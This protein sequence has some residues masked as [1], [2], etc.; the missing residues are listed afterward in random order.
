MRK[1]Q[2]ALARR[3]IGLL[4]PRGQRV[5]AGAGGRV[6]AGSPPEP[7]PSGL[8]V[9]RGDR[10]RCYRLRAGASFHGGYGRWTSARRSCRRESVAAGRMWRTCHGLTSA[11]TARMM[12]PATVS[13]CA[14]CIVP[15]ES[16]FE[17]SP[18]GSGTGRK[19][20]LFFNR[21]GRQATFVRTVSQAGSACHGPDL[22][23]D[24]PGALPPR[25]RNFADVG[26]EVTSLS[27]LR[28]YREPPRIDS[29]EDESSSTGRWSFIRWRVSAT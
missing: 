7:C 24:V 23:T 10:D 28:A 18:A 1:G 26:D 27:L 14:H 2:G 16:L 5:R 6:P 12:P 22:P 9:L 19:P 11:A 4:P 20:V 25:R 13:R 21:K 8:R 15:A 3:R 17:N 29:Y